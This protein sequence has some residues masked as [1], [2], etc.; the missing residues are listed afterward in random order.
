MEEEVGQSGLSG[1]IV[2]GGGAIAIDAS[3]GI[4]VAAVTTASGG[5]GGGTTRMA[6]VTTAGG[7]GGGAAV[8]AGVLGGVGSL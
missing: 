8:A 6:C 3:G 4:T 7:L 5:L 1:A 2:T